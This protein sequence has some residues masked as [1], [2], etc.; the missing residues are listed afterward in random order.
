MLFRVSA[1]SAR[2]ESIVL[3]QK[4]EGWDC[5]ELE[6]LIEWSGGWWKTDG[7]ASSW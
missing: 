2:S 7:Q 6:P 4:L 5:F 3:S 1:A